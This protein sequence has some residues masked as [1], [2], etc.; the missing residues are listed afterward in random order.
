MGEPL[1]AALL[2]KRSGHCAKRGDQLS[3]SRPKTAQQ[4]ASSTYGRQRGMRKKWSCQRMTPQRGSCPQGKG[5]WD[6][7]RRAKG[8]ATKG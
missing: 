2:G 7:Q 6:S 3:R 8:E 5:L 4:D 1:G